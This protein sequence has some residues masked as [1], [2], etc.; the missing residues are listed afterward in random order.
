MAIELTITPQ[1]R[2]VVRESPTE[3]AVALSSAVEKRIAAAFAEDTA[4]GLLQLATAELQTTLPAGLD[5]A[6]SIGRAYLTRLCQTPARD[7]SGEG[8][9]IPADEATIEALAR[10]APPIT[11]LRSSRDARGMGNNRRAGAA[12]KRIRAEP[13]GEMIRCG[14]LSASDAAPGGKPR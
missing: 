3:M 10:D 4:H 5:F 14:D 1:G 11:G 2:L 13:H 7:G 9:P 12:I 8:V 6:R